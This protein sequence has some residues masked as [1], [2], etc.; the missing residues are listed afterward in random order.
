MHWENEQFKGEIKMERGEIAQAL[1]VF[2]NLGYTIITA[3]VTDKRTN[4]IVWR[5]FDLNYKPRYYSSLENYV[6]DWL[7][8][9]T[10]QDYD[11]YSVLFTPG[12][13][14]PDEDNDDEDWSDILDDARDRYKTRV[15]RSKY[16]TDA[17]W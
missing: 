8:K 1:F 7:D 16:R 15:E 11:N 14:P 5:T 3:R 17:Y 6:A 2:S 13:N 10:L 4:D 12:F 9:V